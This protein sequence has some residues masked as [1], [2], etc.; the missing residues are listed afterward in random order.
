[1]GGTKKLS[2]F[3]V[4]WENGTRVACKN[5]AIER[6]MC[7]NFAQLYLRVK[8][9]EQNKSIDIGPLYLQTEFEGFDYSY[10]KLW[11]V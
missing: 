9:N 1:M 2:K 8:I 3:I 10:R 4:D 5:G 7:I 11:L 6:E